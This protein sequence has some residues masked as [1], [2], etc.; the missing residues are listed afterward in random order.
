[1]TIDSG[2]DFQFLLNEEE[3]NHIQARA[4]MSTSNYLGLLG[5]LGLLGE[6]EPRRRR[7]EARPTLDD[8]SVCIRLLALPAT[9]LHS[10]ALLHRTVRSMDG[11]AE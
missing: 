3:E 2:G 8:V 5:L 7:G 10:P 6:V 1:M 4:T 11:I 9:T